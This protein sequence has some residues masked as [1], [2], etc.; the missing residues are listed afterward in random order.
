LF[1]VFVVVVIIVFKYTR[2]TCK[3]YGKKQY[4]CNKTQ[5]YEEVLKTVTHTPCAT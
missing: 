2:I 1:V 4:E 5:S 3:L